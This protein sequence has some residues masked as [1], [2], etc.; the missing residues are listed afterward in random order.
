MGGFV[1]AFWGFGGAVG[2]GLAAGMGW[3]REG[4]REGGGGGWDGA[5]VG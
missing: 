2:D 5:V 1:R 3:G 4:I